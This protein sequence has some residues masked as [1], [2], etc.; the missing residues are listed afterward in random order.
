MPMQKRVKEQQRHIVLLEDSNAQ[1]V[2]MNQDQ[3]V[4]LKQV[5]KHLVLVKQGQEIKGRMMEQLE[6]I[7]G[8]LP[9]SELVTNVQK[10]KRKLY[11][12]EFAW[13]SSK[14]ARTQ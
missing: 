1:L 13:A 9:H 11:E 8:K 3:G 14:K 5:S 6:Q 10:L 4:E 7:C 12:A 2:Q